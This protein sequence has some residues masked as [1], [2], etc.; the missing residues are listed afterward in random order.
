MSKMLEAARMV[1]EARKRADERAQALIDRMPAHESRMNAAFEKH[2]GA[3]DQAETDFEAMEEELRELEGHNSGE[4]QDRQEGSGG[5]VT[6]FRA[7]ERG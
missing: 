4:Q 2:E 5:T 3:L 7:G 6:T 1:A